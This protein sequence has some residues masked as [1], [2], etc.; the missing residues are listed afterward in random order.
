[1]STVGGTE[2]IPLWWSFGIALGPMVTYT[3]S[4][5]RICCRASVLQPHD[6]GVGGFVGG[7]CG[8]GPGMKCAAAALLWLRLAAGQLFWLL[9]PRIDLGWRLL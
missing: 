1:M 2:L 9:S 8:A 3:G 6:D 4:R 5:S 7:Q